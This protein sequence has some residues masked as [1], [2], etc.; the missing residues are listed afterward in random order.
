MVE[1]PKTIF[2]TSI[3]LAYSADATASVLTSG[4]IM[5]ADSK[6]GLGWLNFSM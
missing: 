4:A 5:D 2:A 1:T 6:L 3:H